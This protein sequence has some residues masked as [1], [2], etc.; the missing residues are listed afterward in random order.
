MYLCLS[1]NSI[2]NDI[3]LK[4][5][6]E[7]ISQEDLITKKLYKDYSLFKRELYQNLIAL[8]QGYDK[9][10]LFKKSQKLLDR[11]LFL[12][13]AEDK[14]LLPPNSVRLILDDWEDLIE[15]DVEVPLGHFFYEFIPPFNPNNKK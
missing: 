8:N 14:F 11:F 4:L 2:E 12:F 1:T 7:S 9:L 13:F 10:L 3:P 15:K 5:K 6:S